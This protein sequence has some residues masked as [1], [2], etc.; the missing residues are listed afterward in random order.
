VIWPLISRYV[1][2]L[3]IRASL[4]AGWTLP[5]VSVARDVTVC[6]AGATARLI[7]VSGIA[8]LEDEAGRIGADASLPKPFELDELLAVVA[9]LLPNADRIA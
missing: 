6:S 4:I 3:A 7:A 2:L 1:S 5:A 9:R 8:N